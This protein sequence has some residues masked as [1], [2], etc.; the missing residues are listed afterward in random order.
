MTELDE[1]KSVKQEGDQEMRYLG[2][3]SVAS[4]LGVSLHIAWYLCLVALVGILVAVLVMGIVAP[5]AFF[6]DAKSTFTLDTQFL[7]LEVPVTAIKDPQAIVFGLLGL[8]F[9]MTGFALAVIHQLR[10]V[11]ASLR[12]GTPFTIDNAKR[13]RAIGRLII[14]GTV[15]NAAV[16][17]WV[18]RLM[19]ANVVS[20]GVELNAKVGLNLGGVFVGLVI[21]V[22]GEIFRRGAELQADQDLTV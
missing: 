14:I 13:V 16:C 4:V 2:K 20:P 17:T 3:G 8:G 18:G 11:F 6:S 5:H 9:V 21:L 22:L 7:S 1:E 19:L 12:G 15:A 10:R